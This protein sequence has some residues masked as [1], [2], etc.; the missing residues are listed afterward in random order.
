MITLI[1]VAAVLIRIFCIWWFIDAVLV[2]TTLPG[3][4]LG[5]INYQS[6]YLASQRELNLAIQLVRMFLYLGLGTACLVFTRPL[7][8]LLTKGLEHDPV[9]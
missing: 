7:A 4:I 6:G 9:A 5:I 3:D 2:L 1:Q 8:R